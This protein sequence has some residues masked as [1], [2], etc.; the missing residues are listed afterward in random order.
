MRS[1]KTKYIRQTKLDK[2]HEHVYETFW[3]LFWYVVSE[4]VFELGEK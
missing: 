2:R 4:Y 1:T 3:T